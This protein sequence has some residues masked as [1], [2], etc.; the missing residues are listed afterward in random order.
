VRGISR[1]Q[2]RRDAHYDL[3][4]VAMSKLTNDERRAITRYMEDNLAL[5]GL[6]TFRFALEWILGQGLDQR[7]FSKNFTV[8]WGEEVSYPYGDSQ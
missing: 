7:A 1:T 3:Y 6:N 5:E 4:M 8:L 2:K